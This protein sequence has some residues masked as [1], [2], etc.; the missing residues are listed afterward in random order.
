MQGKLQA[1][2]GSVKQELLDL[3]WEKWEIIVWEEMEDLWS[4]SVL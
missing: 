3:L 2:A 1:T 4:M